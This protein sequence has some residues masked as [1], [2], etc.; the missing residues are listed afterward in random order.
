MVS[1]THL[2]ID[3]S[4]C[5]V[6][7]ELAEGTATVTLLTTRPMGADARGLVHGGFVFG[8]ADYA[9]MLAVND[10]NV[11]LGAAQTRFIAPVSVGQSV[12]AVAIRTAVKGRK[13]TVDVVASVGEKTVFTG[14]F[15]TFI[16]DG[17]VLDA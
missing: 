13:H 11:V 12:T 1:R 4:L 6:P 16:L 14:S 10:P 7:V 3:P 8:L 17:H 2:K 5:G 15:T 9:A